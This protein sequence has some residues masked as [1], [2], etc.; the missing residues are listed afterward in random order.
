MADKA[1]SDHTDTP[2][3][4]GDAVPIYRPSAA[5]SDLRVD[6]QDVVDAASSSGG[7]YTRTEAGAVVRT[8]V[9]F[10]EDQGLNPME[11]GANAD[12]TLHPVSEWLTGGA[13]DRGY[14]DLAAI[15]VDY[16]HVSATTESTDFAAIG[17]CTRLAR[18]ST[19]GLVYVPAGH[20]RLNQM[21]DLTI[22]DG[23]FESLFFTG[24]GAAENDES[25]ALDYTG[26][27]DRP[28]ISI[29]GA[30][31]VYVG[32]FKLQGPSTASRTD[33]SDTEGDYVNNGTVLGR[34]NSSC[35]IAIDAFE[36][37]GA[38]VG[39]PGVGD[40]YPFASTRWGKNNSRDVI[41]DAVEIR[42]F[43]IGIGNHTGTTQNNQGDSC[44][45]NQVTIHDCAYG[46]S[47]GNDQA[48]GYIINA[49]RVRLC[50]EAFTGVRHGKQIG[51]F[52]TIAAQ[53]VNCYRAYNVPSGN[54]TFQ[55]FAADTEGCI[56]IIRSGLGVSTN[57]SSVHFYGGRWR[58]DAGNTTSSPWLIEAHTPILFDNF[59]FDTAPHNVAT[60]NVV[61]T[62]P[63]V[64]FTNCW[65]RAGDAVDD[66]S[67]WVGLNAGFATPRVQLD[68]CMFSAFGNTP[69]LGALNFIHTSP[70]EPRMSTLPARLI[71]THTAGWVSNATDGYF[72]GFPLGDH[73]SA[74]ISA[75]SVG[76]QVTFTASDP[77]LFQVG[78]IV[79]WQT[80]QVPIGWQ[81]EIPMLRVASVVSSTITC[82]K[83][84][85]DNK[86][87][88]GF[89][90][91][92]VKI[93]PVMFSPGVSCTGSTGGGTTITG[94]TADATA[95]FRAGDWLDSTAHAD[96]PTG[97]RIVSVDS[98]S[99][100]TVNKTLLGS[101]SGVRLG[102][103][104]KFTAI[105]GA[106][107]GA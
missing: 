2:Y 77:S 29:G 72:A 56:E 76:A 104:A 107:L 54:E 67:F 11:F 51:I 52:K 50:R 60:L 38:G 22:G 20:Y 88:T 73:I 32:N 33:P 99:Q 10:A 31:G 16:P 90:P 36:G 98:V 21:L 9:Q 39:Y 84:Y 42:G 25:T 97:V 49:G 82:D 89:A 78:D 70:I 41:I 71:T 5:T 92:S 27:T 58:P 48:R 46:H 13:Q 7:N 61:G 101:S 14:A 105:G 17:Q 12:G 55:F 80:T 30:R 96:L 3:Q 86:Y 24:A 106:V 103:P 94:I 57:R 23:A 75:P 40:A 100:V 28:A 47:V 95:V 81:W 74:A 63:F 1:I 85:S 26:L 66:G 8:L 18:G 19:N 91:S 34:Y 4:T 64:K 93:C 59:W 68:N 45:I 102:G 37:I 35:G 87:N 44:W 79:M 69:Q 15:Q 6:L 62:S 43:G 53:V 83:L 65:F